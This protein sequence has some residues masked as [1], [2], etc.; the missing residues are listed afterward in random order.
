M[1]AA[2]TAAVAGLTGPACMAAMCNAIA[3]TVIAELTANAEVLPLP[4]LAAPPG[5]GPVTGV[6]SIT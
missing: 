2:V 5:G 6:G 1:T 3:A 4:A